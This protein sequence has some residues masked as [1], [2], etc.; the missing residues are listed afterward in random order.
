MLG[1]LAG[2][3]AVAVIA[4]GV[5]A[6]PATAQQTLHSS[7]LVATLRSGRPVDLSGVRIDGDIDL[8]P[9]QTVRAP[10]KCRGC[11]FHGV[12]TATGVTF[13]QSVDLRSSHFGD[14]VRMSGA[15][16]RS[17]A[18]FGRTVINAPANFDNVDFLRGADFTRALFTGIA[19]FEDARFVGGG[20]FTADLF[21]R[22]ASFDGVSATG[23][24]DLADARFEG[25]AEFLL[26]TSTGL[27]SF[28]DVRFAPHELLIEQLSTPALVM[29]V[30]TVREIP[31]YRT[32]RDLLQRIQST[33]KAQHALGVQNDAHYELEVLA[34]QHYPF[35]LRVLD[36]VFYRTIAG[37]LVRPLNPL[38]AW[39]VFVAV[40]SGTR[41]SRRRD[42]FSYPW[43]RPR[44]RRLRRVAGWGAGLVRALEEFAD[45]LTSVGPRRLDESGGKRSAL[46]VNISRA[47]VACVLVG[48]ASANPTLRQLVN[49]F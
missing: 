15:T 3:C 48:L 31:D 35:P 19:N 1:R 16:F 26:L 27:V 28:R 11:D 8:R 40:V 18:V 43:D 9:I 25:G 17:E 29:G 38:I 5:L 45:S 34:S 32:K 14:P 24:F 39:L 7:I 47:L 33:A 2:P 37:Y 12:F 21:E 6:P 41:L 49:A 10:L 20:S 36:W 42:L 46:E 30:S 22:H 23:R 4:C 13:D 44:K